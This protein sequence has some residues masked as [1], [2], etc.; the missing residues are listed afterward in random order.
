M[1]HKSAFLVVLV[2]L[3]ALAQSVQPVRITKPGQPGVTLGAS[4]TEP[5]S[6]RLTDGASYY[7]ASGGVGGAGGTQYAEDTASANAEELM[8]CG[9][10]RR[11]VASSSA[12]DGD[13]V[14]PITDSS[15]RLW[16]NASGAA[17]PVTDNAGSLTVDGTFWQATQP[18]S[19]TLT[20]NA[21]TGPF[22]VSDNAGSLTVDG[23]FWQ[24]TQPVSATQLPAALAA[25]GGMKI[26]GVAAGVAVPVS[27]T[28]WQATQPV[29]GTV[30]AN[31]GTAN[32]AANAWFTKTTD[33][34]NTAAVKA[35]STSPTASDPS[36]VVTLSPNAAVNGGPAGSLGV[37][38][39]T[40]HSATWSSLN[41]MPLGA[42]AEDDAAALES[43]SNVET[44]LTRLKATLDGRLLVSTVHPFRVQCRLT[45]TATSSTAVTGC[46]AP[47]AGVSIYVTDIQICG[48]VALG[49]T[50]AASLQWGTAGTCGTGTT[51]FYDCQHPATS[52][53]TANLTTPIKV[54]ANSEIC[55]LDATA[56]TKFVN[57]SG[58][59]AP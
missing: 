50:A 31:Q 58:Y 57:I 18:V 55:I 29:S 26:E 43:A 2:S 49:A 17:I 20:C 59:K 3:T 47:G 25:G 30:T 21:G 8:M 45:T 12:A 52:C 5:L 54:A 9:V 51:V 27:G 10:V 40:A 34:T 35:A 37:A 6:C 33:G 32:T 38:G 16:V 4:A 56:G 7:E 15:G 28:F 22:P 53:C 41:P 1:I 14:S 24:A 39:P 11:D 44:D 19:G 23:T 13:R 36:L 42:Y 48:G 46:T